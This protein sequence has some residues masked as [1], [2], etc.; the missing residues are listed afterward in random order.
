MALSP[1]DSEQIKTAAPANNSQAAPARK[2]RSKV[3]FGKGCLMEQTQARQLAKTGLIVS[4]GVLAVSGFIRNRTAR[5][6]HV[7]AGFAALGLSVWHYSLYPSASP[8]NKTGKKLKSSTE[9]A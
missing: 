7:A 5:K 6:I 1:Q 2:Q 8:K 9:K 3:P 4:M